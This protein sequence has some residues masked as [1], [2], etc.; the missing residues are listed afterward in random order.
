MKKLEIKDNRFTENGIV[1][2]VIPI[3]F[4]GQICTKV[5]LNQR[6]AT[7]IGRLLMRLGLIK[8]AKVIFKVSTDRFPEGVELEQED[9]KRISDG[10]S[11]TA[12]SKRMGSPIK[13]G[14]PDE[15]PDSLMILEVG[16]EEKFAKNYTFSL[17]IKE[18]D[19]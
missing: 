1:W 12:F 15:E 14:S 8:K 13:I 10:I 19:S 9:V 18:I 3:Q 6:P 4:T 16:V 5:W 17:N 7:L 11:H 2:N